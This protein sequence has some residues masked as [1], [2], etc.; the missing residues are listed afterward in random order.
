MQPRDAREAPIGRTERERP[1]SAA[2][3][4]HGV[5]GFEHQVLIQAGLAPAL[6]IARQGATAKCGE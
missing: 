4:V 6:T 2:P 1:E 3:D 5:A